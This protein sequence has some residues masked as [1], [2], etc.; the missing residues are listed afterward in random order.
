MKTEQGFFVKYKDGTYSKP[1]DSLNDARADARAI[2]P[3]L[4][5]LHGVLKYNDDGTLNSSDIHLVP[6]ARR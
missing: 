3:D 6:K 4:E 5:I 2:G 1:Y